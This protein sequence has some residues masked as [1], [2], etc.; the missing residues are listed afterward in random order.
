[1]QM[2]WLIS[3][4]GRRYQINLSSYSS[5]FINHT[6]NTKSLIDPIVNYFQPKGK[7]KND[8]VVKDLLQEYEEISHHSFITVELSNQILKNET[9][10][11]AK[12][13]LKSQVKQE[14]LNNVETDGYM[15]TINTLIEDLIAVSLDNLPVNTKPFTIEALIKHIELDMKLIEHELETNSTMYQNK[16]LLPMIKKFLK[17]NYSSSV[18]LFF[19]FP[20]ESLSPKEQKTMKQLLMNIS[21]GI[22]VLVITQS[23]YFLSDD[24]DSHNYFVHDQQL[25]TDEFMNDLE[26]ESPLPYTSEDLSKS[27]LFIIKKYIDKLELNPTV[28]NCNYADV[29][30]FKSIDLYVFTFMMNRLKFC[31]EIDINPESIDKPVYDYAMDVYE[32]I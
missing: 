14:L 20:E 22:Q 15:L 31:Y 30:I 29:I 7:L 1:M 6:I 32:K 24:L 18:L 19:M 9:L 13:L 26:W 3:K 5:L 27:L 16:L 12:T 2:K 25:F 28:S 4:E 23:K 8:V 11:G 17:D 10:L 21:T